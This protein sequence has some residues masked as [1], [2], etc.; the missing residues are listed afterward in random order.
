MKNISLCLFFLLSPTVLGLCVWSIA[1][2]CV[3]MA[4]ACDPKA[5]RGVTF[6]IGD[7]AYAMVK[8]HATGEILEENEVECPTN[9]PCDCFWDPF[10]CDDDYP[11]A[12]R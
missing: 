7:Y 10:C 3:Y 9:V 4:I 2:E 8:V 1:D 11:E 6:Q 12:P 5:D